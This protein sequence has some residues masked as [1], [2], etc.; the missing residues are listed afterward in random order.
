[1]RL[2]SYTKFYTQY[3]GKNYVS[4]AVYTSSVLSTTPVALAVTVANDLYVLPAAFFVVPSG[5]PTLTNLSH[6]HRS[7]TATGLS[8]SIGRQS[9]V[10]DAICL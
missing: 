8:P 7:D 3:Q 4:M 9:V 1:M 5:P 2:P 10:V 6:G